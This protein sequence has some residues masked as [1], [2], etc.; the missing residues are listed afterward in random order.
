MRDNDEYKDVKMRIK[1]ANGAYYALL[2][3]MKSRNVHRNIKVTLYKTLIRSVVMYGCETWSI[4]RRIAEDLNA[5]ER[6]I[7]K[8][9][10][11]P[12]EE[13]DVWRIRYN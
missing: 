4:T 9:I 11:G 1:T 10:Y 7:L 8:K 13:E 6:T 3:I 12:I 5:F 2:P